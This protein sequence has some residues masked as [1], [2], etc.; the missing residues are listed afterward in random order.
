M[1]PRQDRDTRWVRIPRDPERPE[2][3]QLFRPEIRSSAGI[4]GWSVGD[5]VPAV[6]E[7]N[8]RPALTFVLSREDPPVEI[9]E[10][11]LHEFREIDIRR[12]ANGAVIRGLNAAG[13][14]ER[15][16]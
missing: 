8:R 9:G 1:E 2:R 4:A 5:D 7:E 6:F 15:K 10:L 12:H 11:G 14:G 16:H 3:P 13:A